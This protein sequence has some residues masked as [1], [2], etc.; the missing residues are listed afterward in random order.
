MK[1]GREIELKLE[2]RP[3]SVAALRELPVLAGI[4]ARTAVQSSTYFDTPDQAIRNAGFSL[5]VRRVGTRFIQT[6][7]QGG[8]GA[9]GLFDRP[10]WEE[11]VASAEPDLQR[12]AETPLDAVLTKKVRRKLAPVATVEVERTVWIVTRDGAE[13]EATLDTGTILDGSARSVPIAELEL[14]LGTGSEAALFALARNMAEAV[15]LRLGVL[16]KAERGY[17]LQD[18]SLERATK[19][20]RIQLAP[21][22]S[23]AEGFAAIAFSCLRQFRLNEDLV[24]RTTDPAALHQA[25]VAMRRLRSAFSLFRPLIADDDFAALREEVRWFTDQLGDARNL[26]VL[27]K[28]LGDDPDAA[29]LRSALSAEREGAYAR[30]REALGSARLRRLMLDL[31]AWIETGPWRTRSAADEALPR[32]AAAQLRKRWRKV[33]RGGR[34]MAKLDAEP[35]HRLRIEV[36]K[37]RYASEFLASLQTGEERV[38]RQRAFTDALEDMQEALGE[39][40]DAETGRTLL[41]D[42]LKDCDDAEALIDSAGLFPESKGSGSQIEQAAAAYRRLIEAGKYWK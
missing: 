42:L 33:K 2:L 11:E 27:L 29:E 4:D 5:R 6:V 21:G 16:T 8:E 40:N 34:H 38:G 17:A 3:D 20:E 13:I 24:E 36:K 9:A 12:A 1:G 39:L 35:L 10:E 32:F 31:V 26:D 18:G 25:R 41:A 15:P 28:R 22:M 19:A 37:L 23:A 7:K 14:E 30:V